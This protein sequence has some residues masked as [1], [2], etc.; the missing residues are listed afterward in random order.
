MQ[1]NVLAYYSFQKTI[2]LLKFPRISLKI[3]WI[4]NLALIFILLIFYIFQIN[5]WISEGYQVQDYQKK[6]EKI[7]NENKSL[8][9]NFLQNTSLENIE[10]KI[11][12]LGFKKINKIYYIEILENQIVK[13]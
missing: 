3:F 11:N 1:I 4:L 12:N 10:N 6:I 13:Q 2:A 9:L 7:K 8:E 5:T